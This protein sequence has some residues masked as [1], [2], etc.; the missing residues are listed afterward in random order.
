MTSQLVTADELAPHVGKANR[1][2]VLRAY[3]AGYIPGHRIGRRV[4]FDVDE[5]LQHIK[6]DQAASNPSPATQRPRRA[7]RRRQISLA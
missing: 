2:Q 7:G 1:A 6:A 4:V 5:V 3:R